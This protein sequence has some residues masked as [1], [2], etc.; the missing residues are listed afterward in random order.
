MKQSQVTVRVIKGIR[1]AGVI[2]TVCTTLICTKFQGDSLDLN[3]KRTATRGPRGVRSR[4]R[5]KQVQRHQD[6]NRLI[7]RRGKKKTH[8]Y[9]NIVKEAVS[10]R[11]KAGAQHLK[12]GWILDQE[13]NFILL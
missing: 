12:A 7:L 6:G 9:Q 5:L 4:H 2:I 3:V 1:K 11:D 13:M 8:K 10:K